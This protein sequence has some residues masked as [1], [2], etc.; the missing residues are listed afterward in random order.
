MRQV[1][2]GVRYLIRDGA[3]PQDLFRSLAPGRVRPLT[4]SPCRHPAWMRSSSARSP[5][6][7]R[8][9]A[10]GEPVGQTRTRARLGL[11]IGR[12]PG[13]RGVPAR[14]A[15]S[16][17]SGCLAGRQARLPAHGP[18]GAVCSGPCSSAPRRGGPDAISA[19]LSVNEMD[20]RRQPRQHRHRQPSR[21]ALAM[22]SKV[23]SSSPTLC[24]QP[25]RTPDMQDGSP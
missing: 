5:G 12:G 21:R 11:R 1:D 8:A 7:P 2:G 25:S 16:A 15:P 22:C 24:R 3:T 6:D 20:W 13:L 17:G 19:F 4:A 9:E 14:P 10:S 18:G 23:P